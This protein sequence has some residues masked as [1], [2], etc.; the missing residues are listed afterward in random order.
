[1][2]DK[3]PTQQLPEPSPTDAAPELRQRGGR[4]AD[5][6]ATLQEEIESGKLGP[7]AALDER[8]L[9]T[10]FDVS[11][12][13]VREALQ[14]LAAHGLVR[15]APRQGVFVS[16]LSVNRV[17]AMLEYIAELEALCAKL[18]ARRVDDDLQARARRCR[19]PVR[20][21]RRERRRR[22][23]RRGQH[24]VPRSPLRRQPQRVPG[25]ADP[26]VARR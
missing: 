22:R 3:D 9:A 20:R 25:R 14:Q 19:G 2:E 21:G 16:R 18:A 8:A 11:R 24:G 7:G 12:T 1:M 5:I 15:I 17:R 6:R 10:R 4:A 23:V 26:P 13:P